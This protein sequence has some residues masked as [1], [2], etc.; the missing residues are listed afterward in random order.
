MGYVIT[1]CPK[2]STAFRVTQAQL[3]VAKGSV[4]CGFCLSVFKALD[5]TN[6][7]PAK[8]ASSRVDSRKSEQLA[9]PH[10]LS[11]VSPASLKKHS[12]TAQSITTTEDIAQ[13]IGE[14]ESAA[15][16]HSEN[17]SIGEHSIGEHSISGKSVK[18]NTAKEII[19]TESPLK[20]TQ[21]LHKEPIQIQKKHSKESIDISAADTITDSQI[22][23]SDLVSPPKVGHNKEDLLST[24]QPAPVEMVWNDDKAKG[25]LWLYSV[26][27]LLL[28]L[29]GVLQI[30]TFKFH[31][32]SK[33]Y[34]YR[35]VYNV[36]CPA[37]GCVLPDLVDTTKIQISNL[38]LRSHPSIDNAL[39]VDTVLLN[40][41]EFSQPYPDLLLEFNDIDDKKIAYRRFYAG[42]Y[43]GGEL[44]GTQLMPINQPIQ[45]SI[46]IVDPGPEAVNYQL[47]VVRPTH[48]GR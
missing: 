12:Q 47:Y 41:A 45:I 38:I 20:T 42:E 5:Q 26:G 32:L 35:S 37:L 48:R 11:G 22:E 19:N 15:N 10:A 9:K 21:N 14:T 44:A 16:K 25:R 1:R 39:I 33:I 4:R 46:E 13:Q 29:I 2:C 40:L 17:H 36:V 30:A 8:K 28:I 31:T 23:S 27:V 24:I 34:P 7:S 6:K 3:G 18:L 43:L